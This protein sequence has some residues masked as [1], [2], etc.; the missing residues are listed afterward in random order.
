MRIAVL[1]VKSANE[2]IERMSN[3]Q[4][5]GEETQFDDLATSLKPHPY[6]AQIL[7]EVRSKGAS[8]DKALTVLRNSGISQIHYQILQKGEPARVLFL[9][10]IK[11]VREAV[12]NLIE[13]GFVRLKGINPATKR[14]S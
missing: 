8:L 14:N 7:I 6:D 5:N 2:E 4:D 3:L 13:A 11:D 9:L 10:S 12:L 1:R